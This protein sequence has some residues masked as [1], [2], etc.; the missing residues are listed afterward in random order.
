MNIC[1]PPYSYLILAIIL[2]L[3]YLLYVNNSKK[4]EKCNCN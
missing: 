1:E 2:I 4:D 3:I